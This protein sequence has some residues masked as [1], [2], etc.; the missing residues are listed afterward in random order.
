MKQTL[1]NAVIIAIMSFSFNLFNLN[2]L[3][4]VKIVTIVNNEPITDIDAINFIH[5]ICLMENNQK[6]DIQQ[7]FY[8]SIM[9]IVDSKFHV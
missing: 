1:F 9:T 7:N 6:C 3:F 2:S 8:K 5:I 4:A